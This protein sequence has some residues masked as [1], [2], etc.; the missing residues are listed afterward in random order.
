M[1][2]DPCIHELRQEIARCARCGKCR[3]VCPTFLATRDEARAARGR[4]NLM[5]SILDGAAPFS[6]RAAELLTSCYG[7][8]RC[9]EQCP[10]GVRVD[11]LMQRAREMAARRFGIPLPAR[12]LF[13]HVLPRRRLYD[14]AVRLARFTQRFLRRSRAQPL[15]HLPLL[16]EGRRSVPALARRSA[17]HSLPELHKG[18]GEIKVSL[19]L[20]CLLNYVYPDIAAS[21]LK[22]L[23]LHGVDVIVPKAQLCCGAPVLASGDEEAARRLARR[24]LSCLEP[25]KVDAVVFGCASCALTMKRDYPRL[26]GGAEALAAKITDISEFIYARLGYSNLP[27]D[28]TVTYHDPCHLRWGRGVGEPPREVLRRSARYVEMDRAGDC[29]GLGGSFSLSHYDISCLLGEAKVASIRASGAT[30][31][32]TSCPG[33]ILQ[34]EDQLARQGMGNPVVHVAQLYERSFLKGRLP[35]PGSSSSSSGFLTL[36]R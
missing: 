11:L 16:Y 13:R 33:C 20:G 8:T 19:F 5:E 18:R 27:L 30:I 6:A 1:A 2:T 17:L 9:V 29:C 25:G 35:L 36:S 34:L 15:R 7:C 23:S 4:I 3:A 28:D 26:L 21:I 32:A 10:S 22:I 12:L 24:N 31:V 14:A